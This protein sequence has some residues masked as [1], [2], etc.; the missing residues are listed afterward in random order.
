MPI[1]SK[2][3]N[4]NKLVYTTCTGLMSEDDFKLYVADVWGDL[5][6]FGF[7]ELFDTRQANWELFDF[8][9]LLNVAKNASTLTTIDYNSKLAWVVEDGKQK[10]LT[11]FYKSAKSLLPVNSRHLQA[12]YS[13]AEAL[14]WLKN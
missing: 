3:D 2:T 5:R 12:F 6:H 9:Y 13:E 11:D 14:D 7:N 4:D 8:G 10:K 1:I